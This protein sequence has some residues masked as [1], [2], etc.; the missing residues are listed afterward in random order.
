MGR[1]QLPCGQECRSLHCFQFEGAVFLDSCRFYW[2]C[3]L[4][5]SAMLHRFDKR[6]RNNPVYRE[7]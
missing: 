3:C 7:W 2:H 1:R 4:C 6:G 5:Y